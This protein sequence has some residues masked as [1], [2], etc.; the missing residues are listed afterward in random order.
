MRAAAHELGALMRS[1]D[2]ET[3]KPSNFD[4]AETTVLC[5]IAERLGKQLGFGEVMLSWLAPP[6]RP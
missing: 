2:A 5:A 6:E 4:V 1:S 3:L